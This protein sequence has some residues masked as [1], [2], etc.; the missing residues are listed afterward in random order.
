MEI[1]GGAKVSN[2]QAAAALIDIQPTVINVGTSSSPQFVL[3][4]EARAF[5][6]PSDQ[7]GGGVETEGH[8]F[9]LKGNGWWDN[10]ETMAKASLQLSQVSLS[11]NS[12][13]LTAADTG[14]S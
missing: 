14:S 11:S 6:V 13:S 1:I 9:N 12:L 10:D 5:Q 8:M 2:T 3:W 7:A 4:A